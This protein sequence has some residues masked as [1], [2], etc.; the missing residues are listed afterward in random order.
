MHFYV[1]PELRDIDNEII[2]A[3]AVHLIDKNLVR[4]GVDQDA[5]QSFPWITRINLTGMKLVE[6]IVDES[7]SKI[8][9]LQYE[10]KNKTS[11]QGR[12]LGFIT[13]SFK[14]K[15]IPTGILD[16]AKDIVS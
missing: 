16:I 13:Y 15:D 7:E 3:N 14:F 11:T 2:K 10:L 9:E 12:V 6:R 8:S 5:S 4:G 1:I